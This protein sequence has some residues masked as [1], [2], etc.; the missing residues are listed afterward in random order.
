MEYNFTPEEND[1]VSH[2]LE[3]GRINDPGQAV[4]QAMA[5]WVERERSRI[6]LLDNLDAAE[7]SLA[8][9]EGILITD[10][11][12]GVL[13]RNVMERCKTRFNAGHHERT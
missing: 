10:D 9:G 4:R 3:A 5:L 2:A 11:S 6:E 1:V 8:R 13:A 7:A 12:M